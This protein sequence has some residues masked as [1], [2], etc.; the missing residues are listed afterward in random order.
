MPLKIAGNP[1]SYSAL[2]VGPG[3]IVG[4]VASFLP[5]RSAAAPAGD[6]C[7]IPRQCN[8]DIAAFNASHSAFLFWEGWVFF[9]AVLAGLALFGLR[10]F[11]PRLKTH[12]PLPF[13]DATIYVAISVVMLLC[14]LLQL[15]SGFGR[16]TAHY[17]TTAGDVYT[18]GPGYGIFLGFLAATA[19]SVGSAWLRAA[20]RQAS[21]PGQAGMGV[22][23]DL[24][25]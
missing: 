21:L 17:E 23:G 1:L 14:A 8:A 9:I 2:A 25:N 19:V 12:R 20:P 7:D 22:A 10:T 15:T 6:V 5:W 3:L 11:A 4:L 24:T 18:L 16:G 13:G